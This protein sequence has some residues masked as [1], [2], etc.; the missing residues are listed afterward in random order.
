MKKTDLIALV[1]ILIALVSL[2]VFFNIP[3]FNPVGAI[4]LMSG[5]ILG[6]KMIAWIVPFA[7]IILG[8]FAL[9][10]SS[11]I[12]SD[13]FLSSYSVFVYLSFGIT[14]G[15]GVLLTKRLSVS[16]TLL[17]S[18]IAAVAFFLITNAGSWLM[19]PEYSKDI[20]GLITSY[21]MGLPFFRATLLSQI[22]LSSIIY[23]VYHFVT[24]RKVEFSKVS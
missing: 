3:N 12:H 24:K 1:L 2:R 13:Y 11:P 23:G 14:I 22:I 4:A 21:K 7:L 16:S 8:D 6:R 19:M 18:F 10:L 9:G 20:T 15:I 5:M 17:G